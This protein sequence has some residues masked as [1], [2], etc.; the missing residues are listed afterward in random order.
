[1]AWLV[2]NE[3]RGG[4]AAGF[5]DEETARE[6]CEHLN[7][8]YRTDYEVEETDFITGLQVAHGNTVQAMEGL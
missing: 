7:E 1:M 6:M 3:S 8:K 5:H 2:T 4:G